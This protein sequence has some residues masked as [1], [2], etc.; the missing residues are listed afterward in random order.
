MQCFVPIQNY[1]LK[2]DNKEQNSQQ[3]THFLVSEHFVTYFLRRQGLY[4]PP[5]PPL[6]NMSPKMIF[7]K[8]RL[9]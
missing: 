2:L 9:N 3:N 4:H 5:P 7:F 1:L 6:E 8:F